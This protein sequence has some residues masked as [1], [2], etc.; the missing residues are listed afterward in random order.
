MSKSDK[1]SKAELKRAVLEFTPTLLDSD[2]E[3]APERDDADEASASESAA[4]AAA[5]VDAEFAFDASGAAPLSAWDL[6][7]IKART[8]PGASV[9]GRL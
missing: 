6:S 8:A 5:D 1:P 3:A 7:R 9:R 4:D 2:D